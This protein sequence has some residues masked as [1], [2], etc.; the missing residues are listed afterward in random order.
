MK[1]AVMALT[2]IL[3]LTG[4]L[5]AQDEKLIRHGDT[6]SEL[7]IRDVKVAADGSVTGVIQN[8]TQ[9]AMRDIKLLVKHTWYWR[10]ERNPGEDSPGRSAYLAVPG[11][12]PA[13]G[14]MPFSYTANP[15]L[16]QRGDGSFK[17]TVTV[18]EFTQVGG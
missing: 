1:I 10:N 6:A 14:S 5:R 13:G 8:N 17:T 15:P 3:A 16:P 11:E 4:S 2:L 7:E 12:V 18:Q 9:A